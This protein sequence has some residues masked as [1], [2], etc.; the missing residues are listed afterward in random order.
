MVAVRVDSK[1][2]LTIPKAARERLNVKPGETLLRR[3]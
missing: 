2:R 3:G 1:G